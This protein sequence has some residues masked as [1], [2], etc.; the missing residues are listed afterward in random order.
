LLS[1]QRLQEAYQ[2]VINAVK[3]GGVVAWM[4]K[5]K[6]EQVHHQVRVAQREE[7]CGESQVSE[8]FNQSLSSQHNQ[9]PSSPSL[10]CMKTFHKLLASLL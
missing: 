2:V 3:D 4:V 1:Q 10:K 9:Q 8:A 6:V 5:A 7:D